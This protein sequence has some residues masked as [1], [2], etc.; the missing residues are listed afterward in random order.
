ML[1][2]FEY[3]EKIANA[4]L[5]EGKETRF[6]NSSRRAVTVSRV[7]NLRNIEDQQ[8]ISARDMHMHVAL[9]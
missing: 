9:D 3:R 8:N 2:L 4:G 6:G 7:V 1:L 5:E